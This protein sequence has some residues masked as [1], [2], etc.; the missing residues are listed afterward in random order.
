MPLAAHPGARCW[1]RHSLVV[2]YNDWR[3]EPAAAPRRRRRLPP[4]QP[5][6]DCVDCNA[7][8]AVCPMGIDIRDGQQLECI[9]CALCI[10]ACDSV[11]DKIGK[12]RGLIAYAT[13]QRLRRQHG[14]R[15]RRRHAR[16]STRPRCAIADG[17]FVDTLRHFNW[18][19]I[20]RPRT[21][22]LSGRLGAGGP[23]P[24]RRAARRATAWRSTCCT[25][26]T[27][28]SCW[29][30]DGSIRNGYTVRL[31]NMVPE[32]RTITLTHGRPAGGAR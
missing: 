28:N 27:R 15:H 3:G 31:L 25:T 1:T 11:M 4:A 17:S 20:F 8:V 13:L 26:A 32:P 24:A 16:R 2:T 18:K 22:A 19:I 21:P 6:G 29:T 7:C 9:T 23:R 12:P 10:D 5:V 14:A 30:P